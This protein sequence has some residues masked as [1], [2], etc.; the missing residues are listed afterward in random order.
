[1][2][3]QDLTTQFYSIRNEAADP[4]AYYNTK[5]MKTKS[6]VLLDKLQ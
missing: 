4:T 2:R 6:K 3:K 1:M 5:Q